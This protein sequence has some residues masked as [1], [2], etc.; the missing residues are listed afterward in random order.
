MDGVDDCRVDDSINVDVDARECDAVSGVTTSGTTGDFAAAVP[1][2]KRCLRDC[3]CSPD[4]P[5]FTLRLA[6]DLSMIAL[7]GLIMIMSVFFFSDVCEYFLLRD[8]VSYSTSAHKK[9][10]GQH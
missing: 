7:L 2:G 4:L 9:F 1:R 6:A 3:A 10:F 5:L 8:D